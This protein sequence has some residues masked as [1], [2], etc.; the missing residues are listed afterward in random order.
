[1][2]NISPRAGRT[3]AGLA[4]TGVGPTNNFSF[5]NATGTNNVLVDVAG[6]FESVPPGPVAAQVASSTAAR[7][8]AEKWSVASGPLTQH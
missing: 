5:Y 8:A 3:V 4:Y 2:S 6:S 1:V 7:P